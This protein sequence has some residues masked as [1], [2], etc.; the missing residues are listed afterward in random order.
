MILTTTEY[1]M[2]IP[3]ATKS[4]WRNMEQNRTVMICTHRPSMKK[5]KGENEVR[6]CSTGGKY[7]KCADVVLLSIVDLLEDWVHTCMIITID[8]ET[9]LVQVDGTRNGYLVRY[10]VKLVQGPFDLKNPTG[11]EEVN[12][13]NYGG[14]RKTEMDLTVAFLMND[15]MTRFHPMLTLPEEPCDRRID[16]GAL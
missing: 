7:G 9:H 2:R 16:V 6:R 3:P 14:I 8:T 12:I 1:W 10:Q 11:V 15:S 5:F 4:Y 13:L